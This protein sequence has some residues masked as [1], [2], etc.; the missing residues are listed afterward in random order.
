MVQEGVLEA[1]GFFG[2]CYYPFWFTRLSTGP[3]PHAAS[4][5][6]QIQTAPHK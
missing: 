3:N 1:L 2:H 6:L 5:N 4:D